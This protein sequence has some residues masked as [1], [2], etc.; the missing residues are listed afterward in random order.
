MVVF[1]FVVSFFAIPILLLYWLISWALDGWNDS[2]RHLKRACISAVIFIL[3]FFAFAPIC[4]KLYKEKVETARY[5]LVSLQDSSEISGRARGALF[6]LYA[7][8]DTNDVYT[9]YYTH[10][11]GYKK[12]K[13]TSENIVIYEDDNRTPCIIEY[14][15]SEKLAMNPILKAILTFGW[16]EESEVSYEV[17]VPKGTIVPAFSL[18][19]Q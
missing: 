8:I 5:E 7:S 16:L 2:K 18:D 14:T 4:Q 13:I 12:G 15:T 19:A 9:F 6:Y 3:S 11:G 10:N 17:Y 1:I